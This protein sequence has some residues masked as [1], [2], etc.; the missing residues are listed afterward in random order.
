MFDNLFNETPYDTKSLQSLANEFLQNP[1]Y[2]VCRKYILRSVAEQMLG[3][4]PNETAKREA[5]HMQVS[6]LFQLEAELNRLAAH[7]ESES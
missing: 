4:A 7:N 5:L 3:S 1:A 6:A 2:Q